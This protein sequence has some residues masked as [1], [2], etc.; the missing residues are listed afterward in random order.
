MAEQEDSGPTVC[1]C[2]GVGK[3]TLIKAIRENNANSIEAIGER[4]KAGT[5]CGSC[6][7]ELKALLVEQNAAAMTS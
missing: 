5:N 7:P 1:A 6:L 3:N 2:F 4:L